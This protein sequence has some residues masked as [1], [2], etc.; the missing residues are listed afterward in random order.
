MN[1]TKL[2]KT[3]W[4]SWNRPDLFVEPKEFW[5]TP[6]SIKTRFSLSDGI[7]VLI[8]NGLKD[9]VSLSCVPN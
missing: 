8:A 9:V 2:L 1:S 4:A 5:K 6:K 7:L 3:V